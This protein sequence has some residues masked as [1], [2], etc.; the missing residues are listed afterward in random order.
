[1]KRVVLCA[2]LV[3]AACNSDPSVT[4]QNASTGEVA[5]KVAEAQAS[6]GFIS[7][8]RWEATMTIDNVSIPDMPP[9]I[10][11]KMKSAMGKKQTMIS[12]L[13]PEEAKQPKEGFFGGEG[14][15]ACRYESFTM[16][17]G[18]IASVMKCAGEGMSRTMTMNGTYS[19]DSYR[20]TVASTGTAGANNPVGAMSM[21]MSMD[22]RRTGACTGKEDEE[23]MGR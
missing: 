1:M 21:K 11:E 2:G 6:G 8:G 17:N 3:L 12:C 19:A 15:K 16:A 14:S 20:M 18:K 10:A 23:R 13:T 4:A 22:A 7:P 9:A 5:A